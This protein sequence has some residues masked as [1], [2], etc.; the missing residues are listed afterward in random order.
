MRSTNS[1]EVAHESAQN[2]LDA[3]GAVMQ[4]CIKRNRHGEVDSLG[5]PSGTVR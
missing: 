1:I 2:V 4:I 5:I 3:A